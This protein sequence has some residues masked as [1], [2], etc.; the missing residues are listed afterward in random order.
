M[1]S[2]VTSTVDQSQQEQDTEDIVYSPLYNERFHTIIDDAESTHPKLL[3][4]EDR[5]RLSVFK[6]FGNDAQKLFVCLL[7]RKDLKWHRMG[8]MEDLGRRLGLDY[9]RLMTVVAELCATPSQLVDTPSLAQDDS[10]ITVD[11]ALDCLRVD[12]LQDLSGGSRNMRKDALMTLLK[13]NDNALEICRE[14]LV[15]CVKITEPAGKLFRRLVLIYYSCHRELRTALE[16][17]PEFDIFEGMGKR[18]KAFTPNVHHFFDDRSALVNLELKIF[19][20]TTSLGTR[21]KGALIDNYMLIFDEILST[22]TMDPPYIGDTWATLSVASRHVL[23]ALVLQRAT[24]KGELRKLAC[25]GTF[26][27]ANDTKRVIEELCKE[28]QP[29]CLDERSQDFAVVLDRLKI[30]DIM[31]IAMKHGAPLPKRCIKSDF[32]KIFDKEFRKSP[33]LRDVVMQDVVA[34]LDVKKR[35][36]EVD[37][38]IRARMEV[39]LTEYFRSHRLPPPHIATSP[40]NTIRARFD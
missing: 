6:A 34:Q 19:P 5:Q 11:E 20:A 27:L 13:Q 8:R 1:G 36:L 30:K 14:R 12:E 9:D 23:S 37:T 2:L 17:G 24:E 40:Y 18:F 28:P 39:C 38:L 10:H 22:G 31:T 7:M 35:V 32:P 15:K 33:A 4:V 29:L 25:L 21:P 3:Y 26:D 16:P